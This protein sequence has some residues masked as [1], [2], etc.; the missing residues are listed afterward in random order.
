MCTNFTTM[1]Q[2]QLFSPI[3]STADD[4]FGDGK[5]IREHLNTAL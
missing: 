5:V 3:I 2:L 4:T 1:T